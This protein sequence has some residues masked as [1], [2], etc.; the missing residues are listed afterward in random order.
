MDNAAPLAS[1]TG[2]N[3]PVAASER[4][5][6]FHGEGQVAC[7]VFTPLECGPTQVQVRSEFTLMSTGTELIALH[8]VFEAGSA[9]DRWV[10]YPFSPGYACVGRVVAVGS[11]VRGL[12]LGERVCG[13]LSHASLHNTDAMALTAVP[14]TID[15]QEACWFALAKI[16]SM[17]MR[18]AAPRPSESVLVIGCG[19]VGQMLIRWLHATGIARIIALDPSEARL[20]LARDGGATELLSVKIEDGLAALHE[21]G[22]RPHVVIDCTGNPTVFAH[23]LACVADRGRVILLGDNGNPSKQHLTGDVIFRGL[24]IC[25]AHDSLET[26]DWNAAIINDAFFRLHASGRF[27]LAGLGTNRF[28]PDECAAAYAFARERRGDTMGI[29]FDWRGSDIP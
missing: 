26:S 16:A 10:R 5:I 11:Q 2:T 24:T 6:V 1:R 23:A 4:R 20:R 17:G 22:E 13:R 28:V 27:R 14:G 9:W 29:Y 15:A 3:G 8:R 12:Q 7:E 25:G 19:P 18:A 21:R